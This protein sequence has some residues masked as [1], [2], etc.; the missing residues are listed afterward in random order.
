M[1]NDANL[2]NKNNVP[3][4][5]KMWQPKLIDRLAAVLEMAEPQSL[6]NDSPEE[7]TARL[8]DIK[9]SLDQCHIRPAAIESFTNC[10]FITWIPSDL[11]LCETYDQYKD[12]CLEF[13]NYVDGIKEVKLKIS[14]RIIC[15]DCNY[16]DYEVEK[17]IEY[18]EPKFSRDIFN[19]L[20]EIVT[21][22]CDYKIDE[23]N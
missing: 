11:V 2:K 21:L 12:L 20:K 8:K 10:I 15:G 5:P 18:L 7:R 17:D 13:S 16:Y 22:N 4:R 19:Y 1:I 9:A 3:L 23:C 14:P 6:L